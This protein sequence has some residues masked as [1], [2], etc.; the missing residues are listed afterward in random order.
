MRGCEASCYQTCSMPPKPIVSP[1]P[2]TSDLTATEFPFLS[3][4]RR[5]VYQGV[6]HVH[7]F[8]I[9]EQTIMKP[10]QTIPPDMLEHV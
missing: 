6:I 3:T 9:L 2:M 10:A 1:S 4:H 5:S 7:S 8:E